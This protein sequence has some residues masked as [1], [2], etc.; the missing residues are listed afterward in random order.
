MSYQGDLLVQTE[1]LALHEIT[2]L[3]VWLSALEEDVALF[4]TTPQDE[5]LLARIRAKLAA[6]VP[7]SQ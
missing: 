4:G 5:N 3:E 7:N 1:P 2:E 6:A